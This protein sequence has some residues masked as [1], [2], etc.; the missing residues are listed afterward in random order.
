MQAFADYLSAEGHH[1]W[2]L[3]LDASAQYNDLPDLIAQICQQV[4]ADA[5]QYQR[6]DEYRLLEQMANLRLSGITI[7]CVDT[8]H[9][10]LP[11]AEIP[12]QFPRKQ[13][14]ADGT[15]LSTNA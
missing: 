14:R 6:P 7:G 11:F 15:L 1:V 2:H 9:F 8:E 3:D 4:Q 12:E 5:F 13:S 10:L